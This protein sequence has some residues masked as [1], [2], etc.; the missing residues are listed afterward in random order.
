MHG[1][2]GPVVQEL[3]LDQRFRGHG[4][5]RQLSLLLARALPLDDDQLLIGTIHSDNVT[6]LQSALGAGRVDV[7]G[8]I[9][10]PL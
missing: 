8:E 7:G 1:L 4:Y 5:G 10:I 9:L 2:R 6:A 3:V